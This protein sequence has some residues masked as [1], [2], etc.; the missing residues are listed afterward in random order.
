MSAAATEGRA[1]AAVEVVVSGVASG[2]P[3]LVDPFGAADG[4][5]GPSGL[6]LAAWG[7]PPTVGHG[8]DQGGR[9][10][11]GAALI[12]VAD[13]G[14][15]LRAR[16]GQGSGLLDGRTGVVVVSR[17]AG[18]GGLV[19]RLTTDPPAGAP[20]PGPAL[21]AALAAQLGAQGPRIRLGGP[22]ASFLQGFALAA[23]WIELGVVDRVVL[24]GADAPDDPGLPRWPGAPA[25]LA[26]HA[27]A[28]LLEARPRCEARG[29]VPIATLRRRVEG[30]ADLA[31]AASALFAVASPD[32]CNGAQLVLSDALS[33]VL[34][35][36]QQPEAALRLSLNDRAAL[37]FVQLV[38]ALQ[39]PAPGQLRR[40][41]LAQSVV[42]APTLAMLE[43]QADG[44]ARVADA[45]RRAAWLADTTGFQEP[46][47]VWSG[48]VLRVV[49][50]MFEEEEPSILPPEALGISVAQA[51]PPGDV[52][53]RVQAAVRGQIGAAIGLA[54][55][56]VASSHLLHAHLGLEDPTLDRIHRELAEV[57][58]HS[59]LPADGSLNVGELI[60]VLSARLGATP[61]TGGGETT[62]HRVGP[63]L[64]R[65]LTARAAGQSPGSRPARAR[66]VGEG[67]LADALRA[68]L[69]PDDAPPS[70]VID[71]GSG[72]AE[73][74]REAE[75]LDGGPPARWVCCTRL[76][77]DPA[78]VDPELGHVD[79]A[80]AGFAAGLRAR[81]PGALVQVVDLDPMLDEAEA[82]A[83]L[84]GELARPD[85]EPM[86]WLDGPE[87]RVAR[88][89]RE[90]A[91]AVGGMFREQPVI[92]VIG[93]PAGLAGDFVLALARR[94]QV[95][96][97]VLPPTEGDA[98]LTEAVEALGVELMVLPVDPADAS[99]LR[100][101]LVEVRRRFGLIDGAVALVEGPPPGEVELL[102]AH[103]AATVP[104]RGLARELERTAWLLAVHR[105]EVEAP[106]APD[107]VVDE[108]LR[109]IILSRPRSLHLC[110]DALDGAALAH[111]SVDLVASGVTG[112]LLLG[113]L[114]PEHLVRCAHPLLER[115]QLAVDERGAV[116]ATG[117]A[118]LDADQ[119]R[120]LSPA[121]GPLQ[122]PPA[123]VLEVMAATASALR[124]GQAFVGAINVTLDAPVMLNDGGLSG[125]GGGV[126]H[127][128]RLRVDLW[129]TL[130][131]DGAVRCVL[132]CAAEGGAPLRA[133]EA[134][135]LFG[136]SLPYDA[137][138]AL[139][140]F[141]D[142]PIA[143]AEVAALLP[144]GALLG[145]LSEVSA[146]AINGVLAELQPHHAALGGGALHAA[147]QVL[148][149]AVQAAMLHH[150]AVQGR[151]AEPVTI[152]RLQLDQAPAD[153]L[154]VG[155]MVQL[156]E[157]GLYDVDVDGPGGSVLR[158]RGLGL[159]DRGP[160][161]EARR[162]PVP[163]EG[164][165]LAVPQAGG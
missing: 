130:E 16:P 107:A 112:S 99:A 135:L 115:V 105:F 113:A 22:E 163:E 72:I 79:G 41:A 136:D 60:E 59:P 98:G 38:R 64:W 146:I 114:V 124:P 139:F 57:L 141:S 95:R 121:E 143:A 51:T 53:A 90:P 118:R 5:R 133:A 138:P 48:R 14:L 28:V 7:L 35:L 10:A 31:E 65:A 47:L 17:F 78:W 21:E 91:P 34:G 128:A 66:V 85:N 134:L 30:G 154:P 117:L 9:L 151:L 43:R 132:A 162:P 137:L 159:L 119:L 102:A 63:P 20:P 82:A 110:A 81:W 8:L 4:P 83:L 157:D 36:V 56:E 148:A 55:D 106:S 101:S 109:R 11:L 127:N 24:A 152:S 126:P 67:P 75:A 40:F 149:N 129:A 160:A 144:Q 88:I 52:R 131:P 165:G 58:G 6:D 12:A 29:T 25:S 92:V 23:Q 18:L 1:N 50:G 44:D 33:P 140:F 94:G 74:L 97:A 89:E 123:M 26:G 147:P 116:V 87:R 108:T 156:S 2:M 71:A 54:A 27:A 70:L 62:S 145:G 122:L 49:E 3:E 104:V 84:V 125:M 86:V 42:G 13:A 68:V 61:P 120:P 93:D 142:E 161:P 103:A 153:G 46:L 39:Y 100:A 96:L 150:L 37:A 19:R 164:W 15:P 80:R 69:V 76:G 155:V 111:T 158:L 45:A 77:A 32:E 73:S